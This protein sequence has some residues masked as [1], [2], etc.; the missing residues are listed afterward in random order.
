MNPGRS[1]FAQTGRGIP[2]PFM[3]A[4]I[5]SGEKLVKLKSGEIVKQK[6]TTTTTPG[7][8][9][10]PGTPGTAPVTIKGKA[11]IPATPATKG[12]R[13]GPEFDK[14]Y[15]AAVKAGKGSFEFGGKSFNTAKSL[16]TKAKPGTP[17]T[18]DIT[19][20][21]K[22]AIPATPATP[23]SISSETSTEKIPSKIYSITKS[24]GF[25]AGL[26]NE[27][28][29]RNINYTTTDPARIKAAQE[30]AAQ[31]NAELAER[32][33]PLPEYTGTDPV[34]KAAREAHNAK[35]ADRVKRASKSVSFGEI[36]TN[37]GLEGKLSRD[38]TRERLAISRA[39]NEKNYNENHYE[40][41]PKQ[42][43]KPV[44]KKKSPAK[45]M[46][47]INKIVSK[48]KEVGSKIVGGIKRMDKALEGN[49]DTRSFNAKDT[50]LGRRAVG[51]QAGKKV[52]AAPQLKSVAKKKMA[53][54]KAPAKMKKC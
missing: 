8:E 42:L 24:R 35:L 49:S 32:Y 33:R 52:S 43:R 39:E 38:E 45:Q 53:G 37:L 36:D 6:T 7:K 4:N 9:G 1:P 54:K 29:R 51:A 13:G 23:P 10:T 20:P 40:P 44:A 14:A 21:G 46:E 15:G 50:V 26:G 30:G 22:E 48:A 18:P 17:G 27:N 5:S 2:T 41:A 34:R 47:T 31:Y 3:Q 25:A 11:P 28:V 16:P 12:N 19:L